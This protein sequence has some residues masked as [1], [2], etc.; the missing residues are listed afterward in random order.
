[1]LLAFFSGFGID[2]FLPLLFLVA[3]TAGCEWLI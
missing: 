2:S 1:L 3:R